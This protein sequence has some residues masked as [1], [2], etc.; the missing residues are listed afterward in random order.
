MGNAESNTKSRNGS[1]SNHSPYRRIITPK[2]NTKKSAV[3]VGL[4]YTGTKAALNGCIND[5]RRMKRL[6]YTKFKYRN[7][8]IFTDKN[9]KPQ[10][11]ILEILDDLIKD[12]K[13]NKDKVMYFQYS[14]HGTQTFDVTGDEKDR[15]DEALYSVGGTLIKDDDVHE[16]IKMVPAGVTMVM[17]IDACHSGSIVD[18][19]YQMDS[20]GKLIQVNNSEIKGDV[21]CISGCRDN[22]VSLDVKNNNMWYGA[23]SNAVNIVLKDKYST[24]MSWRQLTN[25]VRLELKKGGYAQV[26]Q[27][28]V[29]RRG[30][31]D[32]IMFL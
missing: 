25:R 27:L 31:E 28:S 5:A 23:L 7:I 14:G 17:V 2:Q 8:K 10:H 30:L 26:P 1:Y 21:I 32:E 19:P 12:G 24:S 4:N 15:M 20:D 29:S 16:K 6:L 22:Q 3:L 11:N 18:L 9:I 13:G